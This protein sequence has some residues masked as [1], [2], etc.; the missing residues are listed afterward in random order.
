M[1]HGFWI[2]NFV[3]L[4][5]KWYVQDLSGK[6]RLLC[7]SGLFLI[8]VADIANMNS[9]VDIWR[10]LDCNQWHPY[11][12]AIVNEAMCRQG[13]QGLLWAT[14]VKPEINCLFVCAMITF[15]LT[16]FSIVRR[17]SSCHF[18]SVTQIII[19]I[20]AFCIWTFRAAFLPMREILEWLNWRADNDAR[21]W[22]RTNRLERVLIKSYINKSREDKHLIG[23]VWVVLS[24][25]G[26]NMKMTSFARN[27]RSLIH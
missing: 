26:D 1:L 16:C 27:R 11:Y 14:W 7:C 13:S 20:S 25:L 9:K 17:S 5:T 8:F 23:L 19:L 4:Q 18:W 24:S 15:V 2:V 3:P 12:D 21:W 10:L 6:R 22:R